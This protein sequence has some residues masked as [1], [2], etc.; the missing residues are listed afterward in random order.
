MTQELKACPFCGGGAESYLENSCDCCAQTSG[1]AYCQHCGAEQSH[2]RTEAEA[3]AA[4]NTRTPDSV[5]AELVEALRELRAND[6]SNGLFHALKSFDAGQR[7]D[8]ALAK[9]E[10][11][12]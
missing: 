8:A 9:L 2:F 6:G 5:I 7:V 3:I 4:W 12:K 10:A 1:V 11:S